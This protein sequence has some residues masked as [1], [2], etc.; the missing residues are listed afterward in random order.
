VTRTAYRL[1][2]G[3]LVAAP[4]AAFACGSPALRMN[5]GT[6]WHSFVRHRSG[7]AAT[8]ELDAIRFRAGL[9]DPDELRP[10]YARLDETSIVR[11]LERQRIDV[12]IER[13][14]ADLMYLN[15]GGAGT[16]LPVRLRV[17]ILA[18]ADEA[19]RELNEGI[20]QHGPGSWGVRRSNL[21]VLGPVGSPGDDIAFAGVTKLACWGVFTIAGTDDT[22]VVPGG[23][24][25]L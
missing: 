22:F 2:R 16:E 8:S 20:L 12:R 11:F 23:Y 25:E 4:L 14:R 10:D 15:L 1:A 9:C 3:I 24:M 17:A 21:A 5:T 7:S 18:T 6:D 19:G 13:P